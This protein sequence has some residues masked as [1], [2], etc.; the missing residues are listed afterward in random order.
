MQAPLPSIMTSAA[1]VMQPKSLQQSSPEMLPD[2]ATALVAALAGGTAP[3]LQAAICTAVAAL[4]TSTSTAAEL[5]EV[6]S[7]RCNS[8]G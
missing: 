2:A 6:V 7:S 1:L 5:R 8:S 3:A 4:I